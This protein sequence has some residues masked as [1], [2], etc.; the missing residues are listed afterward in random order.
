MVRDELLQREGRS[1]RLDRLNKSFEDSNVKD[2]RINSSLKK[3]S[4]LRLVRLYDSISADVP[5]TREKRSLIL[6]RL[7]K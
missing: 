6:N 5:S 4:V 7:M 2:N 3:C 1:V